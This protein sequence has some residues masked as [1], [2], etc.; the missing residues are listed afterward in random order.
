MNTIA[1]LSAALVLGGGLVGAGIALRPAST[2]SSGAEAIRAALRPLEE[3]VQALES[4]TTRLAKERDAALRQGAEALS[5]AIEAKRDLEREKGRTDDI[6]ASL[7]G[8]TGGSEGK[9]MLPGATLASTAG[10][11]ERG[12]VDAASQG[13]AGRGL[14]GAPT[15]AGAASPQQMAQVRTALAEIR[16]QEAQDQVRRW[17]E[18]RK[19]ARKKQLDDLAQRL[20]LTPLQAERVQAIWDDSNARR[21]AAMSAIHEGGAPMTSLKT[22]MQEVRAEEERRLGETLSPSQLDEYKKVHQPSS[23]IMAGAA[24]AGGE[25]VEMITIEAA[26]AF[27]PIFV[28]P[29]GADAPAPA[30]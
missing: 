12:A 18:Q 22:A 28:A 26:P 17:E 11:A 8:I 30:K 25:G 29:I 3:R 2:E 5:V 23:V 16:K 19:V 27:E 4:E 20:A 6:L 21:Q 9:A 24:K 10:G 15:E 7:A 14:S 1:N 13:D